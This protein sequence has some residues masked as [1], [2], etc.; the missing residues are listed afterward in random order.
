MMGTW[1]IAGALAIV[2]AL[3]VRKLIINRKAGGCGGGCSGCAF[4]NDCHK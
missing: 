2:V 1:I 3:V 4:R